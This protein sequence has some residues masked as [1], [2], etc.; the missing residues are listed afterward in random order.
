MSLRDVIDELAAGKTGA[1][2]LGM[3]ES[4]GGILKYPQAAMSSYVNDV[5]YREALSNVRSNIDTARRTHPLSYLAGNVVGS[6]PLIAATGGGALGLQGANLGWKGM[7]AANAGLGA[8][9][10]FTANDVDSG[11]TLRD[12][13]YGGGL[14]ALLGGAGQAAGALLK[15]TPAITEGQKAVELLN[16]PGNHEKIVAWLVKR[17]IEPTDAAIRKL[18]ISVAQGELSAPLA[19]SVG[20]VAGT[21]RGGKGI[22]EAIPNAGVGAVAGGTLAAVTGNDPIEGAMYGAGGAL[23]LAKGQALRSIGEGAVGTLGRVVANNPGL[24]KAVANLAVPATAVAGRL[25]SPQEPDE[26]AKYRIN[27]RKATG[28]VE[29]E[30]DGFKKYRIKPEAPVDDD[31]DGFKKYRIKGEMTDRFLDGLAR[32]ETSGGAKTIKGPKGEDSFNLYNVKDNTG[33]GYRAK[34]KAEGSN[35]AYRVYGST[36]ESKQDLLDL[37]QRKYPDALKAKTP[38]EFAR[39]LKRGGFATDP[40]YE[41]KLLAILSS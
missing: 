5:P 17:G 39:A 19:K 35:D 9:H 28:V 14:G 36:E 7:T 29:E 34:D 31:D 4:L 25:H 21:T 11:S 13:V 12:T 41:K 38:E 26:F 16:Q 3:G 30:D 23:T 8:A 37:L 27:P 2:I 20:L 15:R 24:P 6:A 33:K 40:N 22:L 1:A 18:A 32:L 10:G